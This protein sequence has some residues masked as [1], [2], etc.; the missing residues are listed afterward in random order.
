M[1]NILRSINQIDEFRW[2]VFSY[3][4]SIIYISFVYLL[5]FLIPILREQIAEYE[6]MGTWKS[7]S[8]ISSITSVPFSVMFG[9]I[10]FYDSPPKYLK[11]LCL[12]IGIYAGYFVFGFFAMTL[13][14][15]YLNKSA[16]V[17]NR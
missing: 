17:S 8:I 15:D 2:M 16:G 14:Y 9:Y 7:I 12:I 3:L 4:V 6:Q 1:R 11:D 13:W 10:F 5:G